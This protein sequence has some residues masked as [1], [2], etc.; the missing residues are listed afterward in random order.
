MNVGREHVRGRGAEGKQEAVSFTPQSYTHN[1]PT[2][3]LTHTHT[4]TH[5]CTRSH[6]LAPLFTHSLRLQ[7][8]QPHPCCR[9]QIREADPDGFFFD[10]TLAEGESDCEED[11]FSNG[12]LTEDEIVFD[13][14]YVPAYVLAGT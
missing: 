6:G 11:P 8:P 4:R 14:D 10:H 13:E 1:T 3:A 12:Y 9:G 5:T 2:H 7:A